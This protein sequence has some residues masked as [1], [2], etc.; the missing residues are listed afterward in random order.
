VNPTPADIRSVRDG[1]LLTQ[2][3]MAACIG[4]GY[5]AVQEWEAGRRPMPAAVWELFLLVQV[6]EG[7]LAPVGLEGPVR[8]SLLRLVNDSLVSGGGAEQSQPYV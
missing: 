6:A 7:R 8:P 4:A 5:R 3:E 2:R 1:C